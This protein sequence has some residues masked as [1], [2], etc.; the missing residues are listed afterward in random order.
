[1]TNL[2]V[3]RDNSRDAGSCNACDEFASEIGILPHDVWVISLGNSSLRVCRECR[4]ELLKQLSRVEPG[5]GA[6]RG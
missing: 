1:M 4:R 2:R 6:E 5:K 3:Y